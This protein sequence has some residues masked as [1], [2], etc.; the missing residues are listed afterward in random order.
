MASIDYTKFRDAT[1]PER[2]LKSL[3]KGI[4]LWFHEGIYQGEYF[5]QWITQQLATKDKHT[6]GDLRTDA[7]PDVPAAEQYKLVV[8]TSDLSQGQIKRLPWDYEDPAHRADDQRIADA[9]RASMSIPFFFRPFSLNVY[10][11]GPSVFVDGGMLSNFP[12][13][14]STARRVHRRVCPRSASNS[15]PVRGR[16]SS[17]TRSRATSAWPWPCSAPC[18][19]GATRCTST[20]PP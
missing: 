7:G 8:M 2:I 20:I 18:R 12:S 11:D 9:V 6:F 5:H 10:A 3:A 1:E 4:D 19:A 15:R 17:S 14:P 16:T 13:T